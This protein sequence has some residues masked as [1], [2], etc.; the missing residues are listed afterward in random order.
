[1]SNHNQTL[2]IRSLARDKTEIMTNFKAKCKEAWTHDWFFSGWE[3]ILIVGCFV[4][5]TYSL[6]SWLWGLLG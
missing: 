1:M 4:W 3:K 6:G 2:G 5:T